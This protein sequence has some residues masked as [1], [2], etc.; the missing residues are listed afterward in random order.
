MGGPARKARLEV[1][2][3][4]IE[5]DDVIQDRGWSVATGV[6]GSE[7]ALGEASG[8]GPCEDELLVERILFLLQRD[9]VC[10]RLLLDAD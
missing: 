9:L 10:E 8:A 6:T 1:V 2:S 3:L 5:D 7:M 4:L